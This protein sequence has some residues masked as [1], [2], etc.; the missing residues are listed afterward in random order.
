MIGKSG[1]AAAQVR[2]RAPLPCRWCR[3]RAKRQKICLPPPP[4]ALPLAHAAVAAF[5]AAPLMFNMLLPTSSFHATSRYPLTAHTGSARHKEAAI[6]NDEFKCIRQPRDEAFL[7]PRSATCRAS[8]STKP[9]V[10]QNMTLSLP[11]LT[12]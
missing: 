3:Q 9:H 12:R 10:Q 7:R 2:R 4:L 6:K 8:A 1:N 5:I 11:Q